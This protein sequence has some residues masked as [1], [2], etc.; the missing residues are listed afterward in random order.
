MMFMINVIPLFSKNL[1]HEQRENSFQTAKQALFDKIQSRGDLPHISIQKQLELLE[2]LSQFEFGRFLIERGGLNGYWTH[3]LV[4]HPTKGR[5][6]NSPLPPLEDFLLNSAPT[7]VATQQRFSIFKDSIQQHLCEGGSFASIPSGLMADLLDLDTSSL[8]TFSLHAIDLDS[9]TLFQAKGYAEE[10]GLSAHCH[11]ALKDAWEL[12]IDAKFDLL[13]SNGLSIY[14]P[15]DEKVVSLY[16][17]FY[18][19]LKPNGIL[20][21]SFLTLKTEWKLDAVNLQ[22]ALLQKI[23]FVDILDA[24]WQAF[25]AEETVRTQLNRA[26]FCEIEILYDKAHIFPTVIAKK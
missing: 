5:L 20:V 16:R 11:F 18:T 17:Q 25:R 23:L 10:K 6:Q 3:Y 8:C 22:D 9:E 7:C 21:T 24:K 15:D 14:E 4:T 12:D 1:S 19:A 13:A 2:Q 26:G